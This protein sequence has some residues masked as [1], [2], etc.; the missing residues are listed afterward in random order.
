A[1]GDGVELSEAT[2]SLAF[3]AG[4]FLAP[5]GSRVSVT[6]AGGGASSR[7]LSKP[8]PFSSGHQPVYFSFLARKSSSGCFRLETERPDG[9]SRWG[10]DVSSNG[11]VGVKV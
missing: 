3:P 11:V 7:F 6:G 9:I 2:A 5:A 10:I 8:I 1:A 4:S